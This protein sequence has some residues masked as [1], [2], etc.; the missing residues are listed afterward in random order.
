MFE[1]IISEVKA[2]F[3]EAVTNTTLYKDEL[4]IHIRKGDIR[5]VSEFVKQK[6]GFNFCADVCGA[7]RFTEEDR[8]EVI[9]N[10]LNLTTKVRLRLKL[11]VDE[12]DLHV[13]SV[14]SV[15]KAADW[16]ERETF[17]MYGVIFD[18]HP[19]LR[20]MY[21]PEDFEYYPLRKDYPLI[22]V[23]GSIPMPSVDPKAQEKAASERYNKGEAT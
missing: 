15:W 12:A 9:Y 13:P 1:K 22:G 2:A 10:L 14:V 18:G 23:P 19:D 7:D 11:L 16:H 5:T 4:T 20:R 8:F 6:L 17:D 21:M 3:P